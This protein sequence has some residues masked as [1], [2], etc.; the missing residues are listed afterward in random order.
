MQ[1]I[2]AFRCHPGQKN[3]TNTIQNNTL[4]VDKTLHTD[5]NVSRSSMEYPNDIGSTLIENSTI[6]I[7]L[8]SVTTASSATKHNLSS[9]VHNSKITEGNFSPNTTNYLA[10]NSVSTNKNN[11]ANK[12]DHIENKHPKHSIISSVDHTYSPQSSESR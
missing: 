2:T 11:L 5:L 1:A 9:D 12:G 3:N 7:P 8:S 10:T 6:N 4:S